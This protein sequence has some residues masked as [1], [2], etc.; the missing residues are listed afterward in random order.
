MIF[1]ATES[2]KEGKAM[3][4]I[5]LLTGGVFWVYAVHTATDDFLIYKD[6][7]W[8]WTPMDGCKPY[9]PPAESYLKKQF[10]FPMET[11]GAE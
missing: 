2:K 11:G 1:A 10:I 3:F 4:Q 6:G 9:Y 8:Q 7:A 5:E